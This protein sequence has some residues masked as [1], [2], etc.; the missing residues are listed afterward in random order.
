ML[1]GEG[2]HDAI[3]APREAVGKPIANV[4]KSAGVSRH[5]GEAR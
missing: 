4:E 5:T 3:K 1:A 2:G